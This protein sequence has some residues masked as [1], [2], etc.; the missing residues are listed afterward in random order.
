MST[1][2]ARFSRITGTG[3]FLPPQR[4]T[5]AELAAQLARDGIETSDDWIVERTGIRARH[6]AAPDV[7]S[8]A[9]NQARNRGVQNA[10][11]RPSPC[12]AIGC[13][14]LI[15]SAAWLTVH[16]RLAARTL[17][18]ASQQIS[19]PEGITLAL[20][21]RPAAAAEGPALVLKAEGGLFG[22]GEPGAQS[23][24]ATTALPPQHPCL[25]PM[26]HGGCDAHG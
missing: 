8:S 1:P 25:I 16:L 3:S 15:V 6:F 22:P 17:P 11:F 14:S 4:V 26:A 9:S 18:V 13:S 21:A 5:N 10:A 23:F 12:G 2:S 20:P 24:V 19:T 7:A